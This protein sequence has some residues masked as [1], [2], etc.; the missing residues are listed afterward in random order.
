MRKVI[1]SALVVFAAV[2]MQYDFAASFAKG[3]QDCTKCHTINADQAREV[4]K[5]LIPDIKVLDLKPGPIN[6]I[7]EVAMEAGGKKGILYLDYAKK[8]V[9]AGNIFDIEKRINFTKESFDKINKVDV[10]SIPLE[11]A[12]VMGDKNAKYKVVVFDD[13]D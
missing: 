6:G 7:W 11:K 9:I 4:L 13:P 5:G 10:S 1:L 3:E 12:L 2:L 8:K